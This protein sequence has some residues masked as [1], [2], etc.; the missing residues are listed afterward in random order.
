VYRGALTRHI[1]KGDNHASFDNV[2]NGRTDSG[3]H[4]AL[5][6]LLMSNAGGLLAAPLKQLHPGAAATLQMFQSYEPLAEYSF[7]VEL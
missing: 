1:H 2:A 4:S 6:H 5:P 7:P 3:Y